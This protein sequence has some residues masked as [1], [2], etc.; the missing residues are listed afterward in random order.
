MYIN[1]ISL[2]F[3][4]II[5]AFPSSIIMNPFDPVQR[6]MYGATSVPRRRNGDDRM[7]WELLLSGTG[8]LE[9]QL[10]PYTVQVEK[11]VK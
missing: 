6:L 11:A 7:L 9:S 8:V 3:K 10:V 4:Q 2:T 1:Y 5:Y